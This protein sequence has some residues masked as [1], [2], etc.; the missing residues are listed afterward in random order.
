DTSMSDSNFKQLLDVIA[1]LDRAIQYSRDGGVS[2]RSRGV[3]DC[4]LSRAMTVRAL[5]RVLAARSR[6]SFSRNSVPPVYR[7]RREGRVP[8]DTHGPRAIKKHGE[9]TTGSAG[10]TRPS[11]RNG[12][13]AYGALSPGTGL[14]CSRHHAARHRTI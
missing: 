7:G 11:L 1:R 14:D 13:N 9:G 10:N 5:I 12:F 4:P 8:A 2:L 3:L 6:P